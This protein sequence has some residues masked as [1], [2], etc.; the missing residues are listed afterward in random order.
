MHGVK[1]YGV[2]ARRLWES[3]VLREAMHDKAE[4]RGCD[5][6][7]VHVNSVSAHAAHAYAWQEKGGEKGK[8]GNW[9]PR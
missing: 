3:E 4:I 6:A 7:C 2:T 9:P 5:C 8:R 1:M